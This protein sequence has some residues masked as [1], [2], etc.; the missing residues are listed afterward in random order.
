[1]VKKKK[2]ILLEITRG[3][4]IVYNGGLHRVVGVVT[5][6]GE[7]CFLDLEKISSRN[8]DHN[9]PKFAEMTI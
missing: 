6:L 1:M 5:S 4:K 7:A 3:D 8:I 2:L 9:L